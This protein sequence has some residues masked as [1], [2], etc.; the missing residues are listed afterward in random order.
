MTEPESYWERVRTNLAADRIRLVFV[1]DEIAPE[2]RTIV[3]FLNRQMSETEVIATEVKQYVDTDDARQTIVPRVV[4]RT[5]AARVAKGA[6]SRSV[7]AW[8]EE[9][10]IAEIADRHGDAMAL[11]ARSLITWADAHEGVRV[12]YG[13][14]APD[15]SAGI[16]LDRDGASL[17]AFNIWT[18]PG[19]VE[20]P[21]D[22][23]GLR[24]SGAVC[25]EPKRP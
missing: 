5:E 21:F 23:H 2:L 14:G 4:G 7:R 25:R 15:G 18:S 16:R 8:D 20:I 6:T 22:F 1:A 3:E 19:S 10:V 12:V 24:F 17:H 13:T 11:I 9:S